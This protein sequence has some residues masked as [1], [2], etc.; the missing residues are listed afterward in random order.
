MSAV[1]STRII[2][3]PHASMAPYLHYPTP[4]LPHAAVSASRSPHFLLLESHSLFKAGMKPL[5]TPAQADSVITTLSAVCLG[6]HPPVHGLQWLRTP[7]RTKVTES[8]DNEPY[9]VST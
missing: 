7:P 5:L 8:S 1:G 3:P 6:T 4:G 9:T 2:H